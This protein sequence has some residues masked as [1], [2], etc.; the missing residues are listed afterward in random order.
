LQNPFQDARTSYYHNNVGGYHAAKL[1]RYQELIDHHLQPEMQQMI[2]GLQ[3]GAPRDSVF[4][5][6][7][8]INMLNTR[9]VIYDLN[10]NPIRNPF[11]LGNAWF[12][13]DYQIVANADAEI[14]TMESFSPS[15][16]A[17]IDQRFEEYVEGKKFEKDETGSIEL[18]DYQPNDLKYAYEAAT[19]Q[20]AVFSEIYY[21]K[22]WNAYLEG[23]KVPHFR[24]DYVLRGMVIPAGEHTIEFKFE[25]KSYY[26]GNEISLAS[27][28]LLILALAA[29]GYA[30][31]RKRKK[32]GE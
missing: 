14:Q 30:Q 29:Y 31:L 11:A 2:K 16:T 19:E 12:V 32:S 8:T 7:S 4:R 9:Y 10:S 25:P 26:V 22:G 23:E 1:R 21:D 3:E 18:T 20:L 13:D 17:V 5:T 6:L 28:V 15:E 24:V 27:S